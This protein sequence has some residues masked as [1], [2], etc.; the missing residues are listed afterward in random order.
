MRVEVLAIGDELLD[1]RVA[2]TNTL[3]LAEALSGVGVKI[4]QR[5]TITDDKEVIVREARAI[6]ARGAAL[7]VVSGGLGPTTDDVTSEAFAD[8]LGVELIRDERQASA[9]QARLERLGREMPANQLK[10]ADRPA[11]AAVISNQHGTAPGFELT[12]EG[13]R[14]I[15]VPGVP[16]EFDPMVAEAVIKPL[17][18]DHAPT[19]RV[20]LR[21]FG[22]VEAQ[23][24][25][26]LAPLS[27]RWPGVRLG[28]RAHFPEIQISLK[29]SPGEEDALQAAAAFVREALGEHLFS[30]RS[31]PFAQELV[32]ALQERGLTL[33][34]AES[35]TG[36]L[37]GDLVTDVP[38]SS[39][40]LVQG[41][42]AYSNE[43][44]ERHLEVPAAVLAEHGAVSEETV[45][46][47]ARGIC[48]VSG[49]DIGGAVSGI[50]GPE[51]GSAEK[52]VGTVWLAV[53]AGGETTTRLL[54]LPFDRR[55]N[56][57]VSAY[58][59]LDMVRRYLLG[60]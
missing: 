6:A 49:A 30:E 26:R 44:K 15:S 43:C 51:G 2:D 48:R 5:T 35:C 3:R 58:S 33:A 28:Y 29:V 52:P 36:G 56:K 45:V 20:I 27:E 21:S 7:C 25:Q 24:G 59:G 16:R 12:F 14:F 34:L 42:V 60:K 10:Q 31:G 19:P 32:E 38:G 57:V 1:G 41:V 54:T 4:T 53:E 47:M 17:L 13:C 40:V 23:V 18:E 46:A 39:R 8:L 37:M 22:L 11:G 55:R 9:I 50:A